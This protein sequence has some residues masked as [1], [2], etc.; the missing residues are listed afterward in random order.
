MEL[1]FRGRY[2]CDKVKKLN[3]FFRQ[4]LDCGSSFELINTAQTF[5]RFSTMLRART[6]RYLHHQYHC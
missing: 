6:L 3:W 2:E 4:L 5:V 1:L